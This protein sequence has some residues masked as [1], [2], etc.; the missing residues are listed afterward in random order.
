[1]DQN[2]LVNII[3]LSEIIDLGFLKRDVILLMKILANLAV[4][5]VFLQ[6]IYSTILVN[7]FTTTNIKSNSVL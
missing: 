5:I 3:S 1:M 2:L 4:S 7:L 6:G